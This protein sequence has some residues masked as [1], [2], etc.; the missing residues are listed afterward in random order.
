LCLEEL[1]G[2]CSGEL[3]NESES[4][5]VKSESCESWSVLESVM[6]VAGTRRDLRKISE[7]MI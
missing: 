7:R 5:P 3:K 2:D 6:E 1:V 4:V